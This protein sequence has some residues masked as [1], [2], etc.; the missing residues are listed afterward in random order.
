[1]YFSISIQVQI[2]LA[3]CL[4]YLYDAALLLKPEEGLL[5]P[6]RQGWTG[7]L[8]NRGFELRQNW[9]LWPPILLPHQPLYKLR[10][11]TARIELPEN[12]ALA[13]PLNAHAAS[14]KVFALPLYL[15]AA[16][17]FAALPLSLLV[18]HSDLAQLVCLGLIYLCTAG[19]GLLTLRHGRQGHSPRALARST[20][21]QILLC[22]PF[23]L[24]VVR[25][26]SLAHSAPG[27]LLQNALALMDQPQWQQLSEQVQSTMQRE[28]LEIAEL[29]EYAEHLTQ[30][31]EALKNLQQ[32]CP[33]MKAEA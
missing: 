8:A 26:L 33:P 15:L 25:K 30:M 20:A 6:N 17:L 10:W 22:P 2:V 18:L 27:D 19:I 16:L 12:T 28:I 24:N 5:R 1:L 11:N 23:A 14:F 4:F 7:L 21:L 29:P 13:T 3:I 9:L 31:Q 32:R